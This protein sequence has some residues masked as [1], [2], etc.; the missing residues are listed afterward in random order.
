MSF[1]PA[2]GANSS[3]LPNPL[4]RSEGLLQGGERGGKREERERGEKGRNGREKRPD[5]LLITGKKSIRI[6]YANS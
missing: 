2:G 4:A 1:F 3:T 5:I 6:T